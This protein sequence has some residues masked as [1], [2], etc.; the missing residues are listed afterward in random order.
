MVVALS[1]AVLASPIFG[2]RLAG[3][4]IVSINNNNNDNS[5]SQSHFNQSES[6]Y[7]ENMGKSLFDWDKPLFGNKSSS[8]QKLLAKANKTTGRATK[9]LN[10]IKSCIF[11]IIVQKNYTGQPK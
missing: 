2:A 11:I 3:I 9:F 8:L 4:I 5:G 7:K 10:K 1:V 6:R